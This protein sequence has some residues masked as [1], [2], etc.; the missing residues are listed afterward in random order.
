MTKLLKSGLKLPILQRKL[1]K[2]Y[3]ITDK[4]CMEDCKVK[5]IKHNIASPCNEK[6]DDMSG[7]AK[8]RH[9]TLCDKKV[10]DFAAMSDE[11]I[12]DLVKPSKKDPN[13]AYVFRREDGTIMLEDC[14]NGIQDLKT[15]IM[16][17]T[18]L[19]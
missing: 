12:L 10:Y 5:N 3:L 4:R 14:P 16:Q 15:F 19:K 13:C 17:K 7:D 18:Y 8:C 1:I 6:W 9:C 11:E 2:S